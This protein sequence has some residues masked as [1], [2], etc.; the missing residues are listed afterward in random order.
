MCFLDQSEL[1]EVSGKSL[2][3]KESVK[4]V[5]PASWSWAEDMDQWRN[6]EGSIVRIRELSDKEM[7][8]AVIAVRR[9]NIQRRTKRIEWVTALEEIASKPQYVYPEE[10]LKVDIDEAYAKIEEFY[11]EFAER[12]I[13]P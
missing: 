12:G 10:A 4:A 11:E 6:A 2:A 9:A 13:L 5:A 1:F 7:E 3:T 8:D